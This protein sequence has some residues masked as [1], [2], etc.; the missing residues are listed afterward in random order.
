MLMS[1]YRTPIKTKR[2]Y[3]NVLFH[4]ADIAKVNAWLIYRRHCNQLKVSKKSMLSL[5]KFTMMIAAA[6][7]RFRTIGSP[8]KRKSDVDLPLERRKQPAPVPVADVWY[9]NVAHWPEFCKK[10]NKC[11]FCKT[12]TGRVYCTKCDMCLCLSNSRNCFVAYHSK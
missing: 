6:L 7:T 9:D 12:G 2:W 11:R 1:L 10:E 8:S 5:I 4:C 3:F